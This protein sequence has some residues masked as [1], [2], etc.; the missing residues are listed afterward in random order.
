MEEKR[1]ALMSDEGLTEL[2]A[3][4]IMVA[5]VVLGV[6][7]VGVFLLSQQGPQDIPSMSVIAGNT[8]EMQFTLLHSGGD[9]LTPGSYRIYIV[10]N[11]QPVDRTGEFVIT[12]PDQQ[13]D[14]GELAVYEYAATVPQEVII[15]YTGTGGE[16]TIATV[17]YQGSTGGGEVVD[18]GGDGG[19]EPATPADDFYISVPEQGDTIVKRNDLLLVSGCANTS[20]IDVDY[21]DIIFYNADEITSN[22]NALARRMNYNPATPGSCKYSYIIN[23]D[24]NEIRQI[25]SSHDYPINITILIV[26]YYENEITYSDSVTIQVLEN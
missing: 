18:Q 14:L 9:P 8:S 16:L 11:G 19:G 17:S 5:L 15:T 7:I 24:A 26:G 3:T 1:F 21:V 12:G 20:T 23:E 10:D 6:T 13:W 2:V 22:N 4:I 25:T